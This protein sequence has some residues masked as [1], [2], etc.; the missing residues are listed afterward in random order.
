MNFET[1]RGSAYGGNMTATAFCRITATLF[2]VGGLVHLARA[3]LGVHITIGSNVIPNWISVL[4]AIGCGY[5]A[6]EGFR[7]SRAQVT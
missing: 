3:M 2:L 1:K 5:L 7:L 4:V 6:F